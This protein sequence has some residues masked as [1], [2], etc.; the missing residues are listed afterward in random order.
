MP[1]LRSLCAAVPLSLITMFA[2]IVC[3]ARATLREK[4][5]VN[6]LALVSLLGFF[7]LLHGYGLVG[8]AGA[9]VL[10]E[11]V[12]TALFMRIMHQDLSLPYLRLGAV[13]GPGLLHAAAVG[14]ALWAVARGA[15]G[16]AWPPPIVLGLLMLT[17]AVVLGLLMLTAP[18]P[19]LR[20]ELH[21]LLSRL[22]VGNAAGRGG[23]LLA[24]YVHFLHRQPQEPA[25]GLR[26][27]HSFPSS[28]QS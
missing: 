18:L 11:L 5:N 27:F 21:T 9:L 26:P 22:T 20:R 8:F 4:I 24:R 1:V 12:R 17:G 6:V 25:A 14:G 10:N 3:D 28:L 13:Y 15:A 19:L 7:W 2:G 16:Q 23:R